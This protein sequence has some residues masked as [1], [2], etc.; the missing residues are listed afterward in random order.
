[1]ALTTIVGKAPTPNPRKKTVNVGTP[2]TVANNPNPKRVMTSAGNFSGG[3]IGTKTSPFPSAPQGKRAGMTRGGPSLMGNNKPGGNKP[4]IRPNGFAIV[5][6]PRMAQRVGVP[7]T[8][9]RSQKTTARIRTA[10]ENLNTTVGRKVIN[11]AGPRKIVKTKGR[12]KIIGKN[13]TIVV[14]NKGSVVRNRKTHTVTRATLGGDKAYPYSSG[15]IVSRHGVGTA[16]KRDDWK[17]V[18]T[19]DQGQGTLTVNKGGRTTELTRN[20]RTPRK[21]RVKVT[22]PKGHVRLKKVIGPKFTR[23]T[24]PGGK[25]T[26]TRTR[27]LTTKQEHMTAPVGSKGWIKAGSKMKSSLKPQPIPR[28]DTR[29]PKKP[30]TGKKIH[31]DPREKNG[32]LPVT[33]PKGM[34]A[35]QWKRVQRTRALRRR[36]GSKFNLSLTPT[37]MKNQGA[38]NY[39]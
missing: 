28:R 31:L 14:T 10:R 22:G 38:R 27:N 1:M 4:K 34:S 33:R 9:L 3:L 15:K 12:T 17:A 23:T 39:S 24:G 37:Q 5:R 26:R 2:S 8:G 6:G 30:A 25:T 35:S 20:K 7:K 36:R 29:L 16:T 11:P 21:F 13:K 19:R 18:K 32:T